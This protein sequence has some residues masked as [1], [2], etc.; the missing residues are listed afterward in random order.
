MLSVNE[1][2]I[3]EMKGEYFM[4]QVVLYENN[5]IDQLI[6]IDCRIQIND[7][8]EDIEGMIEIRIES[9]KTQLDQ[10]L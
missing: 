1:Q 7:R 10:V 3:E 2:L 5:L 4:K 6:S 9:F 8:I